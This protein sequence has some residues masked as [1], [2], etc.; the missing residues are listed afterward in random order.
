MHCYNFSRKEIQEFTIPPN[1]EMYAWITINEPNN[2]HTMVPALEHLNKL[3][4]KF[5]DIVTPTPIIGHDEVAMPPTEDQ[6]KEIVNFIE[7]N[8]GK[9]FYVNCKAGKCRSGAICNFLQDYLGY[10]WVEGYKKRAV[11]NTLLLKRMIEYWTTFNVKPTKIIDKRRRDYLNETVL[12]I[13]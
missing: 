4:I 7:A 2:G 9:H 8:K 6:A 11:P 12:H 1:K 10:S 3:K 13:P 5:W